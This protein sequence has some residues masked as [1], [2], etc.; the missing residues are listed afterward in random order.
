MY[1]LRFI[2]SFE[3]FFLGGEPSSNKENEDPTSYGDSCPRYSVRKDNLLNQLPDT[4][5]F[6]SSVIR[7]NIYT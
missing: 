1:F 7:G 5:L 6:L 4:I 2:Y 3:T